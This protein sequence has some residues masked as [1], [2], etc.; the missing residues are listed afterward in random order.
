MNRLNRGVVFAAAAAAIFAM[1]CGGTTDTDAGTTC[2]TD[3]NCGTGKGCHPVLK[4]CVTVCTSGSDCPASEKTCAKVN[5]S[6]STF[7]TC[8]TD[9]LCNSAVPG[10]VCNLAT[11]QCGGKCTSSANCPSGST[12]NTTSGVCSA[13]GG[14]TDGGSDAGTGMDAGTDA[15]V[16][17]NPNNN[18]PDTCGHGSVCTTAM[19][20]EVKNDDTCGNIANAKDPAMP[21]Q[22]RTA[23]NPAT[24]TGA[25]IFN[26]VDEATNDDAFCGTGPTAFTVTVYAYAPSGTM[27]PAQKSG[28]PGFY[29]YDSSGAPLDAVPSVRPSGY[30]QISGGAMMSAKVTL[31]SNTATTSLTAGF[32]FSNGNGY[33][34]N[35][36]H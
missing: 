6:T 16:T 7:C 5:N 15:G 34:V 13:V 24:S 32:A 28:L 12:C 33:C 20:C 1:G 18:Q 10:N 27:F 22:A 23:F 11:L 8:A 25:V 21:T 36:T 29:Y 3:S 2:T 35:I 31:C 17:C 14:G 19:T 4:S 30:T 26:I 9:A